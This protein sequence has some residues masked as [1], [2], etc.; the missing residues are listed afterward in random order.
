MVVVRCGAVRT[1][2][3][4]LWR[5]RTNLESVLRRFVA[6][7][8]AIFINLFVDDVDD[9]VKIPL[10]AKLSILFTLFSATYYIHIQ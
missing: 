9:I 7:A 8:R 6:W 1:L 5:H 3:Y 4:D 2:Q 10:G